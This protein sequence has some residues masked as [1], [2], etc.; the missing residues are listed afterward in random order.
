MSRSSAELE[1]LTAAHEPGERPAPHNPEGEK[2]FFQAVL[3]SPGWPRTYYV[4]KG[5]A[6]TLILPHPPERR[7]YRRACVHCHA[8]S[9]GC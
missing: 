1:A 7:D 3:C 5:D 9:T 2:L 6:E 4:T 8:W